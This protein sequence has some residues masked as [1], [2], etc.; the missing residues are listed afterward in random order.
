LA[1][2]VSDSYN[3][4]VKTFA[5]RTDGDGRGMFQLSFPDKE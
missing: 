3:K 1:N 2:Y 5:I 4:P